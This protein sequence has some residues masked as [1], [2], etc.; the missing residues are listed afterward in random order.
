MQNSSRPLSKKIALV[1]W[2]WI[3]RIIRRLSG[4]RELGDGKASIWR[5]ALRRYRGQDWAMK[6][7]TLLRKGDYYLEIHINNDRL[8]ALIDQNTSVERMGIIALREVCNGL[9]EVA[10]LMQ[11]GQRYGMAKVLLGI[12]LLHRGTERVG[13][14]AYD[15]KPGFFRTVTG[16][17][18]KMLLALFHPGGLNNL[19]R[20]RQGLSPKYVVMT[21]Q[22]IIAQYLPTTACQNTNAP[23]RED[24][25]R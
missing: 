11:S 6:D 1:L 14:T 16:W 21:R 10:K 9:P 2:G 4:I 5:L 19:K 12:T 22:E 17:Y 20:Y 25:A 8:L 13:F 3:D 18:E 24:V 23:H 15:L 7:G